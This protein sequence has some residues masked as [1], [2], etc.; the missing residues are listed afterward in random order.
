M[1]P[2]SKTRP[3]TLNLNQLIV[4][5]LGTQLMVFDQNGTERSASIKGL[6]L[7]GRIA[8]RNYGWYSSA[9]SLVVERNDEG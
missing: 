9:T 2:T 7:S 1:S 6:P 4:E 8:M 3:E 5:D